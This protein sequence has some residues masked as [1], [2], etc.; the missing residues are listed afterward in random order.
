MYRI[1]PAAYCFTHGY[2]NTMQQGIQSAHAVVEMFNKYSAE[3][4]IGRQLYDWSQ[5]HKTLILL[6]GGTGTMFI[7]TFEWLE[8][9]SKEYELPYASFYEPDIN[10]IR[11][12]CTFVIT[13]NVI[14]RIKRECAD[15]SMNDVDPEANHP[16]ISK[17]RTF[18]RAS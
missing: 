7:D 14:E 4:E 5:R 1:Y 6:N 3:T 15:M 11:T 10:K 13:P 12:S 2:M 16:V 17:L 9:I 18:R 8:E